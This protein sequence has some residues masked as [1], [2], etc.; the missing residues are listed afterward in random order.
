MVKEYH[1][2]FLHFVVDYKTGNDEVDKGVESAIK[3][4]VYLVIYALEAGRMSE[5]IAKSRGIAVEFSEV[6][7]KNQ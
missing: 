3:G 1:N 5:L 7:N 2:D 6:S 4:Y